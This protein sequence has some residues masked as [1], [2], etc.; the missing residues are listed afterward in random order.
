METIIQK[1]N[2]LQNINYQMLTNALYIGIDPHKFIHH[3][4]ITNRQMDKFGE[5]KVRNNKTDIDELIKEINKI[6]I[7]GS[8]N[9]IIIGIEGYHGNGDFIT[10]NLLKEF[11][12][13]YEIPVALT[14][15]YRKSS[16]YREKTDSIDAKGVVNALITNLDKLSVITSESNDKISMTLR[17]LTMSRNRFVSNR[18]GL[19]NA[20]H[21]LM[22]HI[23]PEYIK[24]VKNFNSKKTRKT[25]REFCDKILIS[26]ETF[27]IKN[28]AE[29]VISNIEQVDNFEEQI[30]TIEKR[31]KNI[32]IVSK[33]QKI[34]DSF[35]G[36]SY[37]T[38]AE[39]LSCIYDIK[40][41]PTPEKFCKYC[42][43]APVSLSSGNTKKLVNC[44]A[45]VKSLRSTLRTIAIVRYIR[46]PEDK[47][48]YQKQLSKGKTKRQALKLVMR[49][50]ALVLYA[51]L[52]KDQ[53]YT[54]PVLA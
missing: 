36:L 3:I 21:N 52:R 53:A 5:F 25:T 41:F 22:Q 23:D 37:V 43:I 30:S 9:K 14:S 11:N 7:E 13:I 6:Q 29:L 31:I 33:Y 18:I 46:V 28:R 54:Y 35:K 10:R 4:L 45:G 20:V 27:E 32:L 19:K 26:D 17:D 34:I 49:R 39:L 24:T 40:R 50:N 15:N 47:E 1:T 44:K 51:L 2:I 8:F 16:I 38:M 42:G 48:Y 12:N